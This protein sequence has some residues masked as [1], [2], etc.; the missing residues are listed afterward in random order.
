VTYY[1]FPGFDEPVPPVMLTSMQ[2][3]VV[4][5]YGGRA[6]AIEVPAQFR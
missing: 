4:T 5:E 6:E 2:A 3:V 1:G